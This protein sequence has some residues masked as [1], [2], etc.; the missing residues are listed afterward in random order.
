MKTQGSGLGGRMATAMFKASLLSNF[1]LIWASSTMSSLARLL[2]DRLF[3][4]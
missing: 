3:Q 2:T 1:A 4:A